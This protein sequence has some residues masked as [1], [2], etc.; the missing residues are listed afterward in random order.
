MKKNKTIVL[1]LLFTGLGGFLVWNFIRIKPLVV[2]DVVEASS[3]N[4]TSLVGLGFEKDY[5]KFD[6]LGELNK[7]YVPVPWSDNN[8]FLNGEKYPLMISVSNQEGIVS[9]QIL[10]IVYD[11][12]KIVKVYVPALSGKGGLTAYFFV[13]KDGSTYWACATKQPCDVGTLSSKNSL[14]KENLA[15]KAQQ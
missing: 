4:L 11:G 14:K 5:K 1:I 2:G 9:E 6:S 13:D 15:R 3:S 8:N 10:N 12:E 7:G